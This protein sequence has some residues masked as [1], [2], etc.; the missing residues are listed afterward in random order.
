MIHNFV[1]Y[2]INVCWNHDRRYIRL[3]GYCH[4][5]IDLGKGGGRNINPEV[6][7]T[8]FLDYYVKSNF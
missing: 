4:Q 1:S 3:K 6:G 8:L 5:N 7:K 2:F